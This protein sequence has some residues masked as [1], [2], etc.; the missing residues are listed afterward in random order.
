MNRWISTFKKFAA[1][2]DGGE[3]LEYAIVSGLVVMAA[4]A[5]IRRIGVKVLAKWSSLNSSL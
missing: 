5:L 3:T 1:D 2:E 4:I